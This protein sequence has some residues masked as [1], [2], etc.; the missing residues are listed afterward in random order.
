MPAK[1]LMIATSLITSS[2]DLI[3]RITLLGLQLQIKYLWMTRKNTNCNPS[4][5]HPE[6]LFIC[7][8]PQNYDCYYMLK[9]LWQYNFTE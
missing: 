2:F 3:D 6:L 7:F 8:V 1:A 9:L 4:S 5:H